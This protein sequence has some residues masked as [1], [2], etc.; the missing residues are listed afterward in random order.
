MKAHTQNGKVVK[1]CDPPKVFAGIMGFNNLSDEEHRKYGW[2]PFEA[3]EEPEHDPRTEKVVRRI[4]MGDVVRSL[5]TV[6]PLTQSEAAHI[7]IERRQAILEDLAAYRWE[8]QTQGY[9]VDGVTIHTDPQSV[10]L[11][12]Q[13]AEDG[14]GQ[15][16]KG[17]NGWVPLSA[18][19][20]DGV[21]SEVVAHVRSCFAREAE[22][23]ESIMAAD[24]A[25]LDAMDLKQGW[26]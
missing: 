24:H 22:L 8:R 10:I 15:N 20:L 21:A 18:Q 23:A 6:E 5:A 16:W 12:R 2:F 4:E 9:E 26:P 13:A 3:D 14:V 25:A 11:L 19:E 1:V 7:L 17:M